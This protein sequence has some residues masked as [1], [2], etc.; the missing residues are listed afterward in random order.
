MCS[1]RP[2]GSD[3]GSTEPTPEPPPVCSAEALAPE[4]QSW[5]RAGRGE[6]LLPP[7][8]GTIIDDYCG[9]HVVPSESLSSETPGYFGEFAMSTWNDFHAPFRG[10]PAYLLV[11][12][13]V[14]G[15]SMP[16]VYHC[17]SGPF[18]SFTEGDFL[19]F[20]AWLEAGAPDAPNFDG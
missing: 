2:E 14:R 18:G 3:T 12:E 19:H 10:R 7:S 15:L 20:D 16:P 6:G 13:R 9:C 8:I 1:A 17:G 11:Q 5:V 4:E